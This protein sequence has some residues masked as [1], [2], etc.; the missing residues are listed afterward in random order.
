METD[1]TTNPMTDEETESPVSKG[2]REASDRPSPVLG[3]DVDGQ[4]SS[5]AAQPVAAGSFFERCRVMDSSLRASE[6][7]VAAF[8]S[9]HIPDASRLS[10]SEVARR[11]DTSEA[12][13]NRLSR[14]LGYSGYAD[15]R[16]GLANAA[17]ASESIHNIPRDIHAGDDL[18]TVSAKL[19][20]SLS[21]A[22]ADTVA[23]LDTFEVQRAVESIIHAQRVLVFG[24]GG[25][26]YVA[27]IAYHLFLKAGIIFS[28]QS[29]GYLQAV[30]AALVTPRDVVIGVSHSGSTRD[31]L[32]A[33]RL[34]K[35]KGATT[36]ALT[37][38]A[39]SELASS[40]DIQLVTASYGE[41]IYGDFMEA[42]IAQLFVIDL[43]YLGVLL[44][45]IPVFKRNLEATAEAIWDRSQSDGAD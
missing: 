8:L 3:R 13:V 7:K 39:G 20:S 18:A 32:A 44:R 40:V 10:I 25:S 45:D 36:V 9:D 11:S 33:L 37:G 34:A 29:D 35:S 22:L 43:L 26:G 31:I 38:N 15:M 21:Q 41:P 30:N 19:A 27:N 4:T 42:K 24:I 16:L 23:A 2:G 14:T 5:R 17:S 28:A 1:G 12:T 6:R